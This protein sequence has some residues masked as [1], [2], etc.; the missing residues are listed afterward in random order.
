MISVFFDGKCNLCSKEINYYRRIAPKNTFNWVDITKTPG[1]LDK[2][3][4]KLSDGLRLMHVADSRG[5]IFTG[6]DAFIIMWKQIK[7][8]KFLGLFV[9]LPIVKQIANLLY[10]YFADWRFNRYE[11]CLIAQENEKRS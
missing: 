4:I 2:F 10:Q 6:V 9:S 11:H 5:N 8:W 3:E 7:Y 1:E